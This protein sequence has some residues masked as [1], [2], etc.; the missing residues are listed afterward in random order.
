MLQ[1]NSM[2]FHIPSFSSDFFKGCENYDCTF[3][4]PL[5]PSVSKYGCRTRL[6]LEN[7]K[8][9]TLPPI[10]RSFHIAWFCQVYSYSQNLGCTESALQVK[11]LPCVPCYS[12]GTF[13]PFFKVCEFMF[14]PC[15]AQ[16]LIF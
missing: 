12:L 16:Q 4:R 11:S 8:F 2:L 14:L 5:L 6:F 10:S 3:Q 7:G 13:F 9:L 15:L 1:F